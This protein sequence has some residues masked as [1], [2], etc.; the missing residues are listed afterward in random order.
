[1]I[2]EGDWQTVVLLC[3]H[4]VLRAD[5]PHYCTY[6]GLPVVL[7]SVGLPY[8]ES[9]RVRAAHNSEEAHF[10]AVHQA[11]EIG[12]ARVLNGLERARSAIADGDLEAAVHHE[13]WAIA[14][15]R[16]VTETTRLLFSMDK[17]GFLGQNGFR[18]L[19]VPAS[20][21]ESIQAREV[22]LIAGMREDSPYMAVHGRMLTFRQ[23]MDIPPGQRGRVARW[24]TPRLAARA[25]EPS[26]ACVFK[27]ALSSDGFSLERFM[28]PDGENHPL[29][30]VV[31]KLWTFEREYG[32]FR[33]IR[34]DLAIHFLGP[35]T[36]G[37]AGSDGVPYLRAILQ[38]A[39]L[40]PELDT[41]MSAL[42]QERS[43]HPLT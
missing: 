34:L 11:C 7:G 21:A 32:R 20:G 22:E 39:R 4:E 27:A 18:A 10:V 25:S 14:W 1:M 5:Q 16:N 33:K 29:R 38:T 15:M 41:I 28:G 26:V 24:W 37:T 23:V 2:A 6:I 30:P 12:L 40:Y 17:E 35:D 8:A 19:V 9:E 13:R 43:R 36:P 3:G 42:E 31:N